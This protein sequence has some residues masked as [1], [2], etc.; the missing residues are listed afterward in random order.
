MKNGKEDIEWLVLASTDEKMLL[1]S[2]YALTYMPYNKSIEA[3]DVTWETSS[4]RT[5]L[6]T[7]FYEEVFSSEEKKRILSTNV[8]N[9]N[10]QGHSGARTEGGNDTTDNV[11]LISY[12]EMNEYFEDYEDLLCQATRYYI[13]QDGFVDSDTGYVRW[14]LRS[15]GLR[16]S[17]ALCID[18]EGEY[19]TMI[20]FN[21][22]LAVRPAVWIKFN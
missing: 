9:G 21:S 7:K 16:Q 10:E 13:A 1:I 12:K 20:A 19:I 3:V 11:F 4:L 14:W 17:E 22:S 15:P 2:K 5:W 6:N 18:E 8:E